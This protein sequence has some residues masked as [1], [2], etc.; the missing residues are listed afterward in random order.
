ML[1]DDAA[2]PLPPP[3]P[4]RTIAGAAAPPAAPLPEPPEIDAPAAEDDVFAEEEAPVRAPP[5]AHL[6]LRGGRLRI[7]APAAADQAAARGRLASW[8]RRRGRRL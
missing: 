5:Q 8:S 6:W 2:P 7:P 4:R 3:L 1:S